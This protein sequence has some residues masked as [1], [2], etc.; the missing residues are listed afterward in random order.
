MK[1]GKFL[2]VF[3]LFFSNYYGYCLSEKREKKVIELEISDKNVTEI[4]KAA[5]PTFY[6]AVKNA[7]LLY[8]IDSANAITIFA[9]TEEAFAKLKETLGQ[10]AYDTIFYPKTE[11]D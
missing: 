8:D 9:P 4:I 1:H 10:E 5:F 3:S 6:T 2:I 7:G 11:E